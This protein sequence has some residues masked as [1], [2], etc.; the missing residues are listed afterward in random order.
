MRRFGWQ[1]GPPARP[2]YDSEFGNRLAPH[3]RDPSFTGWF[4]ATAYVT[5]AML[6]VRDGAVAFGGWLVWRFQAFW[7]RHKLLAAGSLFLVTV[8]VVRAIS[9]HHVEVILGS[10]WF[11]FMRNWFLEQTWIGLVSLVA[12]RQK[13]S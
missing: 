5:G 8:I 11:G 7:R 9:F 3:Q 2:T 1:R 13:S 10:R 6:A 12:V 4:T